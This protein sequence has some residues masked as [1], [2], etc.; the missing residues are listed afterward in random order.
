MKRFTVL[1]LLVVLLFC[2][3]SLAGCGA[4]QTDNVLEAWTGDFSKDN[5]SFLQKN[6]YIINDIKG[7]LP[8]TNGQLPI[9]T[10]KLRISPKGLAYLQELKV[11]S[12]KYWFP[13]ILS[14]LIA[15]AALIVSIYSIYLQL[16]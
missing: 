15:I 7:Y 6:E 8:A 12:R 11:E 16:Q 1:I 14:N 9:R 2:A 5:I 3:L 4:N 13:I 10:N